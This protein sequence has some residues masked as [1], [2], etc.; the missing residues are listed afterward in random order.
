MGIGKNQYGQTYNFRSGTYSRPHLFY[1][2]C[3]DMPN[4]YLFI[5][6][7]SGFI[8]CLFR[9][10]FGDKP[11]IPILTVTQYLIH[12][13]TYLIFGWL[14]MSHKKCPISKVFL[15][16]IH[17]N[18]LLFFCMVHKSCLCTKFS[19]LMS[20]ASH[21]NF[22]LNTHFFMTNISSANPYFLVRH[23]H[24]CLTGNAFWHI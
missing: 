22:S 21:L 1:L 17:W 13:P 3:P 9:Y 2:A 18:S 7:Y 6:T 4:K 14:L 12:C 20:K 8:L 5:S 11:F 19:T 15:K 16:L 23:F 10:K 24:C